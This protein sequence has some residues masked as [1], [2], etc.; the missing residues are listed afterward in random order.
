MLS[1]VWKTDL[2]FHVAFKASGGRAHE[3]YHSDLF[4]TTLLGPRVDENYNRIINPS[5]DLGHHAVALVWITL[6]YREQRPVD[7][8]KLRPG[9]NANDG[10]YRALQNMNYHNFSLSQ[11]S[12]KCP[13]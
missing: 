1:Q 12:Q 11:Y 9:K 4:E 7:W 6:S 2:S 10:G 13:I 3:I 8:S 5:L